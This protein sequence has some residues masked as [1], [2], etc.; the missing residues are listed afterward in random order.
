M[1]NEFRKRGFRP[2]IEFGHDSVALRGSNRDGARAGLAVK[3]GILA[4]MVD[5][6]SMMRMLDRRHIQPARGEIGDKLRD[7]GRF[8]GIFPAHDAK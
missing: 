5:I 4:L 8:A 6:E 7:Q 1:A 3:E 2:A